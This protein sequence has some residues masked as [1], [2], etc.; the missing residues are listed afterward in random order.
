MRMPAIPTCSFSRRRSRPAYRFARISLLAASV[1]ALGVSALPA[2]GS[3]EEAPPPP[4]SALAR[5]W[6]DLLLVQALQYLRLTPSQ[7]PK[8][9]PLCRS[10]EARG[11][12]EPE[13]HQRTYTSLERL[14]R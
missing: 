3:A 5:D 8:L 14:L 9:L 4:A 1:A 10:V 7:A 6:E 13:R 2:G 12:G 11:Q